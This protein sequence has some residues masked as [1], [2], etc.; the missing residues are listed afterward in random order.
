MTFL[1]V[2][3]T[4]LGVH[5]DISGNVFRYFWDTLGDVPH[6][7]LLPGMLGALKRFTP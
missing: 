3:V 1:E 2:T 4:F 7:I 6:K 5:P